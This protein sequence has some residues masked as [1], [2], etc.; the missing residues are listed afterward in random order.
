MSKTLGQMA[1]IHYGKSPAEVLLEDGPYPIIGTGGVY[2]QASAFM[3]PSGIVVPRKGSLGNPQIIKSPFWPV[4]TTYAVIPNKNI[5]LSWLYYC[6]LNFDLTKLNEATGVPS[7][8][9]DWLQKIRFYYPKPDQQRKI[10]AILSTIDQAIEKTELL[11]NKYQQIKSG[12]MHDLFT[13][14]VTAGGKLRPT[15][16]QAPELY[17]ET[18]IGWFPNEWDVKTLLETFGASNIVNGPFGSD[19]LTS[20]L[21]EE[22]IPVIYVQDIKPGLFSR[23]AWA[24]VT[25]Q[26]A[27]QLSFCNVKEND[28]LVA[29]VGSPP[30]DSCVYLSSYKAIVTQD[31]IRIRSV[32][33]GMNAEYVSS[34]LNSELGRSLIRK[35]S[36]EGTRERV[37]L[38]DFKRVL[39]PVAK[40]EEQEI[41]G[42]ILFK[43]QRLIEME[44]KRKFKYLAQKSGLMQD[45]L[46]GKV[47]V[48]VDQ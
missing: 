26:K 30:C 25:D 6:L 22:G 27:L 43:Y 35:I 40:P 47:Q 44:K 46:T 2:G 42:N 8:S 18:P 24:H 12:L 31:V 23:V 32:S 16:E 37:S 9:R 17:K 48:Q 20:E 4:D 19:L 36:I 13:R 10:G 7:I 15:R 1:V 38:T 3:F 29:K 11:I 45:L 34:F 28:V 5:D 33:S 41:I 39:I 14:G 21:H